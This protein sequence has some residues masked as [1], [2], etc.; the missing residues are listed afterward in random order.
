MLVRTNKGP[1]FDTP[2]LPS[3]LPWYG[4]PLV[5]VSLLV[6]FSS[7][8]AIL[9][10][11]LQKRAP[12][13]VEDAVPR[14]SIPQ[15][16]IDGSKELV[17]PRIHF[18]ESSFRRR[19]LLVDG[20]GM[21]RQPEIPG[22]VGEDEE[23]NVG[24]ADGFAFLIR[25][26][27]VVE[28]GIILVHNRRHPLRRRLSAPIRRPVAVRSRALLRPL[29]QMLL[30]VVNHFVGVDGPLSME[31]L[32]AIPVTQVSHPVSRG[33]GHFDP[34][35]VRKPF[36]AQMFRHDVSRALTA[37]QDVRATHAP[38]LADG[39]QAALVGAAI[40]IHVADSA[41]DAP[42][43][44]ALRSIL[45]VNHLATRSWENDGDLL[46]EIGRRQELI[47]RE[48][49]RKLIPIGIPKLQLR[50]GRIRF[51][52]EAGAQ[53]SGNNNPNRSATAPFT[54]T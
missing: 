9:L 44:E 25:R 51:R 1:L 48:R 43:D 45:D 37:V 41:A 53:P 7:T 52:F 19:F 33:P 14:D 22:Q 47:G 30:Q 13:T 40:G 31:M 24:D 46:N 35:P 8:E 17:R 39:P 26:R 38:V 12:R 18:P 36:R 11:D 29:P 3:F 15:M 50:D 20:S 32:T 42:N 10:N 23:G 54:R 49:W 5:L 6:S 34:R 16:A 4:R 28:D 21:D 2:F 27:V